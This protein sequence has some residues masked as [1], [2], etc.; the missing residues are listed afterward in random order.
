[1]RIA[2]LETSHDQID[3]ISK[4]S[5]ICL[6]LNYE[7]ILILS[8]NSLV[9][10]YREIGCVIV[11][12]DSS[13]RLDD[14][15]SRKAYYLERCTR[16]LP[17]LVLKYDSKSVISV[18]QLI[19]ADVILSYVGPESVKYLCQ[20][21][22]SRVD[23]VKFFFLDQ[24]QSGNRTLSLLPFS[25]SGCATG[26]SADP[27]DH[28]P[29]IYRPRKKSN[30]KLLLFKYSIPRFIEAV[31]STINRWLKSFIV[32]NLLKTSPCLDESD[33][34]LAPQG[35]TEASYTYST[36][37]LKS[38]VAQLEEFARS[39]TTELY[40]WRLHPHNSNRMSWIDLLTL[41][42]SEH[43]I[44]NMGIKMEDSVGK[45]KFVVALSSNILY[46][47]SLL[48]KPSVCLGRSIYHSQPYQLNRLTKA[49]ILHYKSL[50]GFEDRE[51]TVEAVQKM[52]KWL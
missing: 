28:I 44:E 47:S 26:L 36:L 34:I 32:K 15:A 21:Y 11:V 39:N 41:F 10:F 5:T 46:D 1:M 52:I 2:Y 22:C 31:L 29:H 19:K 33:V 4:I 23:G 37:S 30:K 20:S 48:G 13:N 25:V 6:E 43:K 16:V 3:I 7:F 18:V 51:W 12:I 42:R 40:R 35:F 38:P 24:V 50:I 17:F 45:C 49:E 9:R 27:K 8:S 14:F